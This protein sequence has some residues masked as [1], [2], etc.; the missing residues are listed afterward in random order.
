GS[1]QFSALNAQGAVSWTSS[2]PTVAT[3]VSTGFATTLKRGITQITVA[4]SRGS[5]S[6]TLTVRAQAALGL[7]AS[8]LTFTQQ[9][10]GAESAAQFVQLSDAGDD[11]VGAVS[12][13]GISYSAGQPTGWLTATL[14]V[15]TLPS[16]LTVRSAA[17]SLPVGTYNATVSL[18]AVG[19]AGL[20]QTVNVTFTVTAP[21]A[22]QLSASTLAFNGVRGVG[23][24]AA[25]SIDVN[26]SGG[27]VLAGL[28]SSISYG[29]GQP[30][31]WLTATLSGGT[32]PATLS[33][34]PNVSQLNDGTYTATISV[35]AAG[36]TNS[37]RSVS[38]TLTVVSNSIVLSNSA[39]AFAATSG[40]A[41][42]SAQTVNVSNGGTGTLTGLAVAVNYSAGQPTGWLT[43]ASLGSAN[44]PAVL[45]LRPTVGVL[46]P[47]SYTATVAVSS[48]VATNSAQNIT[49]TLV[50][51]NTPIIALSASTV[52][53]DGLA[54]GA[55][56]AAK[57]VDISNSG[58]GVLSGLAVAITY[59]AGQPGGWLTTA[60]LSAT[61][62]P[63]TLTLRPTP[64]ALVAGTYTANV[65]VSSPVASNSPQLIIVTF[66]VASSPSIGLSRQTAAFATTVGGAN[67]AGQTIAIT[68]IGAPTLTGLTA[69]VAYQAGQTTGW[70]SASLNSANDPST[71]TLQ[72]AVG[73]L[74]AGVYTAT[75]S[76]TSPVANNSPQTVTVTFTVSANV[77]IALSTTTVNFS[78]A[79][80]GASPA[81]QAVTVSNGGS[82]LLNQLTASVSY[83]PGQATG[84]LPLVSL[85]SAQATAT[86]TLGTNITGLAVGTYTAT[87]A[88]AS[89]VAANSPQSVT[90]TLVIM[91]VPTIALSSTTASFSTSFGGAQPAAQ[92]ITVSNSGS[93][94]LTGL[95]VSV[96]YTAGQTTGWLTTASLSST[97]AT[98]TLQLRPAVMATGGVFN[99]IVTITSPV[100]G[101]S[102]QQIAVTYTVMVSFA[103]H[104]Y[105]LITSNCVSCHFSSGTVGNPLTDLS[106]ALIA[107][108]SLVNVATN[109][110]QPAYPY[111]LATTH[112]FRI[113]PGNASTSY[114]LDQILKAG[115]AYP[116]P[117]GATS[118][119]VS[120]ID[121]F[122]EWINLGAP[123]N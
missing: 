79:F 23:T 118:M 15:A 85:N 81:S 74:A 58:A 103:T 2:D 59:G 27:G 18:H 5:A 75:V 111:P 16:T 82:G 48:P 60:S 37:P 21:A 1:L 35:S 116:M 96:S 14:S 32:A 122:R 38:V 28:V 34:Q 17:G 46:A 26:N 107:Y 63:S 65:A 50:V 123:F 73:A 68:N 9:S 47:G 39:V 62:N 13:S 98:S 22:I 99:A 8:A 119:P 52:S 92:N 80:G 112:P 31:G 51:S 33:V 4:D 71:L 78:G 72:V 120:W 55:Q 87:V 40:G 76:I 24:V 61:T 108:N 88:V 6:T 110:R 70:L 64:G 100:A 57:T 84:W 41:N 83:A 25:Q 66:V 67:P 93:G 94:L 91:S 106:S 113:V 115:G 117:T 42:P 10:G 56:P 102:P 19:A 95:A 53:F 121:R 44:A 109:K 29:A 11:K 104:I 54:G 89:P 77:V 36:A 90:V 3:L 30:T 49:V 20:D 114:V 69:A 7:S 12:V 101:N 97:T 45:T 105:P 86:L 43:T